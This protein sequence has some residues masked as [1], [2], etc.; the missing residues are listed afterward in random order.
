METQRSLD[1][2]VYRA[3]GTDC[4][5]KWKTSRTLLKRGDNGEGGKVPGK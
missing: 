3:R 5:A 4:E 1:I 2:L